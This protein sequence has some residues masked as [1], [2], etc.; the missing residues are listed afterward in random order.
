M[1]GT[2]LVGVT[3]S[4][5]Y[6]YFGLLAHRNRAII[7]SCKNCVVAVKGDSPS[8]T[9]L[10]PILDGNVAAIFLVPNGVSDSLTERFYDELGVQYEVELKEEL[11]VKSAPFFELGETRI[12]NGSGTRCT[13]WESYKR[14]LAPLEKK[15]VISLPQMPKECQHNAHMFY[16]K[17]K[18]LDERNGLLDFLK[19]EQICA[20]FHY[21][22]LHSSK[23]G[24]RFARFHGEDRYTTAES[25]RLIRL[26]LYFGLSN[27][28]IQIV[29][30]R[31]HKFYGLVL[32]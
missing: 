9:K 21:V 5:E 12:D 25:D 4:Y 2:A 23:A 13:N 28:D 15:G 26:P 11:L 32:S 27:Q 7:T 18:D 10:L 3:G 17:V 22:P 30:D 1:S 19:N 6:D 16:I 29:V 24:T 8:L 14:A 31:I 20:V